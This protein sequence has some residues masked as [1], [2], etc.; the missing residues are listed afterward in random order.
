MKGTEITKNSVEN[1]KY[2]VNVTIAKILREDMESIKNQK[3]LKILR[4]IE[5]VER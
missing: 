1:I 2:D 4:D 5:D 3:K